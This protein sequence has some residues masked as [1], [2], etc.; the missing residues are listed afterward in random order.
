MTKQTN[1][2]TSNKSKLK[3]V[4]IEKIFHYPIDDEDCGGDFYTAELIIDGKIALALMDQYHDT[5]IEKFE[6]F[7]AALDYLKIAY[8]IQTT[9]INDSQY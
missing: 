1:L 5:L 9:S 8:E 2:K 3:P 4:Q 7:L 6:G